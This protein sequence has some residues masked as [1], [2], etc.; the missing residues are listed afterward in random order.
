MWPCATYDQL[1]SPPTVYVC[2]CHWI[3]IFPPVVHQEI[4][5]YQNPI[6]ERK[7]ER[8]REIIQPNTDSRIVFKNEG[9]VKFFLCLRSIYF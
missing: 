3:V 5:N 2:V 1:L 8:E 4:V 9:E 6:H 7:K